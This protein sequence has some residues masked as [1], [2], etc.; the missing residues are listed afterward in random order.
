MSP[1]K[2]KAYA[3][4]RGTYLGE[5][6]FWVETIGKNHCF[7]SVPKNINRDI[8]QDKFKFGIENK[9]LDIVDIIP[10]N[11]FE[12]LQAQYFYNKKHKTN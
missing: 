6:L 9:I 8:P 7:I 12:I 1:E 5:M 3:V 2:Y 10:T 4:T 11:V